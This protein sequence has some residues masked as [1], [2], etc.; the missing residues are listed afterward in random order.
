[1][2]T[3]GEKCILIDDDKGEMDLKRIQI[4]HQI[5]MAVVNGSV[6]PAT[7]V[8]ENRK[9]GSMLS[10]FIIEVSWWRKAVWNSK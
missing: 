4:Y 9:S 8:L 3:T 7:N 5:L 10:P 6:F 1:M 2:D